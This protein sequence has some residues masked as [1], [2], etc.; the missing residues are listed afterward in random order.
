MHVVQGI[1]SIWNSF[2]LENFKSCSEFFCLA[3]NEKIPLYKF[4]MEE[5]SSFQ[6]RYK[7]VVDMYVMASSFEEP[8]FKR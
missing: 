8:I 5:K 1:S 2:P 6:N 4:F 7:N 3:N